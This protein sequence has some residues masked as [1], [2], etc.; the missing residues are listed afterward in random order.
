MSEAL[1]GRASD[2]SFSA[3]A[4]GAIATGLNRLATGIAPRPFSPLIDHVRRS[5]TTLEPGKEL[6]EGWHVGYLCEH[7]EAVSLGQITKL[8]VNIYPRSLK[9]TIV[10][11]CWP[12]WV[13]GPL[14]LPEKRFMF[15][16][17]EPGLSYD[18]AIS[19]RAIMESDEYKAAHPWVV[20]STDQNEKKL[21]Q[22]TRRG[23]FIATSTLGAATGK[24]GDY[25][26][27]DDFIDPESAESD[28][29]R[30]RAIAAWE[31]KF[32]SRLDNPKTGA[33]V[34][35]EQRTHPRDFT[36]KLLEEGGFTHL[37]IPSDNYKKEP[38]FF[39]FPRSGRVVEIAPGEPTFPERKP[40]DIVLA[41]RRRM[42][43][44]THDA[45]ERQSPQES[46]GVIFKRSNWRYYDDRVALTFRIDP[47][48]GVMAPWL[49]DEIIQSW[50]LAFKDTDASDFVVGQVWGRRGADRYLLDQ[51]RDQVGVKGTMDAIAMM[52]NK[53][54]K[55]SRNLVEDKANGPAVIELM[56]SKV[57]GLIAVNPEG[58][59]IVRARAIEPFH[60]SGNI[61]IPT[62]R[63]APWIEE[64]V[65]EAAIFPNAGDSGHDD[66]VD[67]M[68][69]ANIFFTS[70]A[71]PM[72][73]IG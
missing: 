72:L 41:Q 53:W 17:H 51:F 70:N 56:K 24:G 25:L 30:N 67:A 46:G 47:K 73:S 15:I 4:R 54:P 48:T 43:S 9:S 68:T 65:N 40:M 27:P 66:Q 22:N 34:A 37:V 31:K 13:W 45:Q 62:P 19:R 63:I 16:S 29:E 38:L 36:A 10:S 42:G 44:R 21:V 59:K 39:S 2:V 26:V 3:Q 57:P 23:K 69:Q 52:T 18:L 14:K 12:T 32:S 5:W 64:F 71:G 49:F 61:Y 1:F 55:A 6:I 50:D 58:G 8:I 7:L 35:I 33:V 60:E 28:A 20:L 11:V